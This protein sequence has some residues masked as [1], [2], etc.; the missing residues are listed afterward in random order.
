MKLKF[1]SY[2]LILANLI[3]CGPKISYVG[4]ELTSLSRSRF[5]EAAAADCMYD[6][7]KNILE[8][9]NKIENSFV[10][11]A[12]LH[13]VKENQGE[14]LAFKTI[15]SKTEKIGETVGAPVKGEF[16]TY[17]IGIAPKTF[18]YVT[19]KLDDFNVTIINGQKKTMA[20][21]ALDYNTGRPVDGHGIVES[22]TH[23]FYNL[24]R[25]TYCPY[26]TSNLDYTNSDK[27]KVTFSIKDS[28]T[29]SDK[30]V[31]QTSKFEIS[32][33]WAYLFSN[34]PVL[35]TKLTS[36]NGKETKTETTN[37]TFEYDLDRAE[38]EVKDYS[39]MIDLICE[40]WNST[41]VNCSQPD[42]IN[43]L[44]QSIEAKNGNL[45]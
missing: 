36:E 17:I 39:E 32:T 19:T 31:T 35:I 3:A 10:K 16:Q 38:I 15:K 21:A 14:F 44:I 13:S 43:Q 26:K 22:D 29:N 2:S 12:N 33:D 34:E 5:I 28:T 6:N 7:R 20:S 42:V 9:K 8:Y 40:K 25:N 45:E 37:T 30:T 18:Y 11:I 23:D 24:I 1:L 41:A 4:D 27:N